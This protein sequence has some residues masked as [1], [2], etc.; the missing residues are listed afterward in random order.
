[1]VKPALLPVVGYL[2]YNVQPV[3]EVMT[4]EQWQAWVDELMELSV[5]IVQSTVATTEAAIDR[6]GL[7]VELAALTE[8][9]S[10][11]MV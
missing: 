8:S 11:I 7:D 10:K 6:G 5:G 4:Q 3:S 2:P 1:M 9:A